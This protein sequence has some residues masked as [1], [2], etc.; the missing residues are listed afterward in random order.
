M[1]PLTILILCAA[2]GC[3]YGSQSTMPPVSSPVPAINTLLPS[4]VT[5]NSGN[6]NL[7]V[8]GANFASNAHVNF[9]NAAMMTTW[10]N[11]GQVTAAIP[12]SAIMSSG[13]VNV[14][15]T[16]PGNSTGGVYN[17]GTPSDTGPPV[18]FTINS[19][20]SGTLTGS[21]LA[22]KYGSPGGPLCAEVQAQDLSDCPVG[23]TAVQP[24]STSCGLGGI[25]FV[26]NASSCYVTESTSRGPVAVK[27]VCLVDPG[28]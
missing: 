16:N 17:M 5:A 13:T 9:N 22:G 26:D 1:K 4:G 21:C 19:P 15:V 20:P 3:G 2:V 23:Q 18:Q 6:F 10:N 7:T 8:N 24:V 28:P 14:T 25:E 11:S 27:G 12:N